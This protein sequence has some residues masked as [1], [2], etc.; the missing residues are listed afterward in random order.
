MIE[1]LSHITLSVTDIDKTLK[2]LT[3]IFDAELVY[4]SRDV[5]FSLYPEKFVTIAGVWVAIMQN[6]TQLPRS[7]NHIAFKIDETEFEL[8]LN[9]LKHY[10]VEMKPPRDRVDGEGRSLYFYDFD[11]HLFELHTSTLSARL[12]RYN[13]RS[14]NE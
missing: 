6:G 12:A 14:H 5:E 3:D 13:Q 7:Y 1:G 10:D 9:K 8:Y 11:N 4:E 2:F